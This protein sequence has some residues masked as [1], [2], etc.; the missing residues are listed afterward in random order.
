MG[1]KLVWL[2]VS[3][4]MVLSLIMTSCGTAEEDTDGTPEVTI[5]GGDTTV[6]TT[7]GG[8]TEQQEEQTTVVDPEKPRYGGWLILGS[9]DII[10]FD[11]IYGFG[12]SPG[13]TI[14]QTNEEL[15]TGDWAKGPAGTN[16]TD[17]ALGGIN[18]WTL[19]TGSIA[20]SWDFSE[21]GVLV[22]HIRQGNRFSLNPNSE[23]SRMVGGREVT[24]EDCRYSIQQLID[25]PRSFIHSMRPE[26]WEA[27][28]TAEDTYT[29]RIELSS[30]N[31][32]PGALE[33]LADFASIIPP[34][35]V[36]TYGD[37][38]DWRNSCG[39]GP[40]MLTDMVVASQ[41]TLT[42]NP[43][44]WRTNPVGPGKGDKLP[45]I[46]GL[47]Y[48]IITDP[49]TTEA[50]FRTGKTYVAQATWENFPQFQKDIPS[51]AYNKYYF[52]GGFN[53]H[54]N[55][56][57]GLRYAD[58]NLRRALMMATDYDSLVNDLFGGD[59]MV[60]VWPITYNPAYGG[61]YLSIEEAPASVQE[62]YTYNPTKAKELIEAAGY[63]N[64]FKTVVICDNSQTQT[65]FYSVLK[66]MW[67]VVDIELEIQPKEYGTW[68]SIYRSGNYDELIH[69]SMS[70][71]G[72]TYSGFNYNGGGFANASK[73][74]EPY[75][76]EMLT[77]ASSAIVENM[78]E[79][80]A[81]AIIKEL[82]A[83]VL[84][85]AYA[86]PYPKAP[87]YRIWWPWVK[88]YH[89]EWSMGNWNANNYVEYIW[90]DEELRD[91]M[92]Y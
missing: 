32:V 81:D 70:G 43:T 64:G 2:A 6:T 90:L 33:V 84:D 80:A 57:E 1:K 38:R 51:L 67:E 76:Q 87:A 65:D 49:S 30:P 11:E 86:L 54:F 4:L 52:D 77:K 39:T 44:Y 62:L 48:L 22:F 91:S 88:N 42:R 63:P 36:E 74:N 37:M 41:A 26:L 17:W 79:S 73:V 23:A 59:A 46:D 71:L 92:G 25:H 72:D 24:A 82:M 21:P 12:A 45:Y 69:S 8:T 34:E 27:V 31:D 89:G 55:T 13:S 15:W 53:C 78:D 66:Q 61:A 14:H 56:S 58:K 18:R 47:R 40:F 50:A 9:A 83:F 68:T 28:I 85:Q 35:I 19:K 10:D 3:C 29:L 60:N 5:T 75:I 7:G 20:E 16:E